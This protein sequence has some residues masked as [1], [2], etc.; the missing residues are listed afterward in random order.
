M[1]IAGQSTCDEDAVSAVLEGS[2]DMQDINPT[3]AQ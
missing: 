1:A 2:Q 3:T